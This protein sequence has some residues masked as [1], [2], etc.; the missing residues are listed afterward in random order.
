MSKR[1]RSHIL[2]RATIGYVLCI[3]MSFPYDFLDWQWW[4]WIALSAYLLTPLFLEARDVI[5]GILSHWRP[6]KKQP[7]D[8]R[9]YSL[10]CHK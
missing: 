2:V 1:Q 5:G 3:R 10:E 9:P 6:P 8:M 7:V 4:L